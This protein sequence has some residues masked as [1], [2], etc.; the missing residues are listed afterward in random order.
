MLPPAKDLHPG[1]YSEPGRCAKISR[2]DASLIAQQKTDELVYR[3]GRI[4]PWMVSA[5]VFTFGM[6]V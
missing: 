5:S 6:D 1:L 2:E 4:L 3:E